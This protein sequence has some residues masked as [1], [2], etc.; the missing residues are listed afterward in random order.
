MTSRKTP[1]KSVYDRLWL[2][3]YAMQSF[4]NS[5]IACDYIAQNHLKFADPVYYPLTVAAHVLYA[6]SFRRSQ[7]SG[8]LSSQIVPKKFLPLHNRTMLMRDKLM[9]HLDANSPDFVGEP[10][11]R[12]LLEIK[13]G[14]VSLDT[15][16]VLMN[17]EEL[18][19]LSNLSALLFT[20][21]EKQ[22]DQLLDQYEG[23]LPRS[24]G[25]YVVDLNRQMFVPYSP[26][27]T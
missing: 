24:D 6:R 23:L 14:H 2:L 13:E 12:V 5:R 22:I 4:H 15:R 11:N 3:M 25:K 7:L 18:P 19:K 1:P 17:P 16:R 20:R 21:A 10:G 27:Q 9:A 26:S 8:S